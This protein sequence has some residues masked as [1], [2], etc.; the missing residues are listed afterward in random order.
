[1]MTRREYL[2]LA[3]GTAAAAAITGLRGSLNAMAQSA[4]TV[5]SITGKNSLKARAS[6]RGLLAGCAVNAE[7]LRSDEAFRN[8]LAEQYNIVVAEYCMKW[9]A[10]RPTPD[11]YSF[12]EADEL[13]AFA[14]TH[15]MKVRG[16]NFV[17]H[18]SLPKWFEGTVNKD[19][20]QKFMT[21]H[22]M[23]VGGRY[24]GRIHSWDVVNEAIWIK[25]GRPDGLRSSS[26]WMQMLGPEYIDTAFKTARQADPKALLTYNEYGIE[27]DTEEEGKKREAV[28]GLLRRLKTA[29]T[30]LDALGIQ[31]HMRAGGKD[32]FGKGVTD[33]I[34]SAR[35]MGLQVF[36]T[37]MD[38]NDEAIQSNDVGVID[39]EVANVY[40]DY[41]TAVLRD[42]SVKAVLTWGV[43]DKH[44]WM[45]NPSQRKKDAG[46]MARPLP[47][48]KDLGPKEAFF[49][50]RDAFD[51]AKKR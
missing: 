1:M 34:A 10:L 37:E 29:G 47:F 31:S 6:A 2:K 44:A 33:L 27:Y 28:L 3:T 22:I 45:N 20:A 32:A 46:R 43:S 39:H 18:E 9:A 7:A 50:I 17:W 40:R 15:G 30:P 42:P 51:G 11:S 35:G 23:T 13:M 5:K 24:K 21:D 49:A 16:H 25:D 4:P 26:P 48:D 12:D 36:I 8:L 19:N 41:L 14:Q 38:V